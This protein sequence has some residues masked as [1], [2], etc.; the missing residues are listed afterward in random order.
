[1]PFGAAG[2][3]AAT[4]WL[5]ALELFAAAAGEGDEV[6]AGAGLALELD[7]ALLGDAAGSFAALVVASPLERELELP[8]LLA[9]PFDGVWV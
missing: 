2:G 6:F 9:E 1:M 5:A 4:F 7:G 8:V 3:T